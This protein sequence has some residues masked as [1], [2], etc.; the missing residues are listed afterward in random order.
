MVIPGDA[1]GE[2]VEEFFAGL[3]K[4]D[5]AN[6]PDAA[7]AAPLSMCNYCA[8]HDYKTLKHYT[9]NQRAFDTLA[10]LLVPQTTSTDREDA[11]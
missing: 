11:V 10:V 8:S 4:N 1:R 6:Q 2:P 3:W 9:W 7:E 5:S